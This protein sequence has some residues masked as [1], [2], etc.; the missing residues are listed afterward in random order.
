MSCFDSLA[1]AV[2]KEF[3]ISTRQVRRHLGT[4]ERHRLLARSPK[5]LHSGQTSNSGKTSNN[6]SF[7]SNERLGPRRNTAHPVKKAPAEVSIDD[8]RRSS[9]SELPGSPE[10]DPWR[11]RNGIFVPDGIWDAWD[12][13]PAARLIYG[14]LSRYAGQDG[15]CFPSVR[16][17]AS[18]FGIS[19]RQ[20]QSHLSALERHGLI[21]REPR[22]GLSGQTSNEFLFLW[23]E[24]LR[25]HRHADRV[26]GV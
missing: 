14:R 18:A 12:I 21:R 3:G 4:L 13:P 9:M 7:P 10:C 26:Q 1:R 11:G 25:T 19:A 8:V 20:T 5:V 17:V 24:R 15:H 16:A 23:S 22:A 6:I 2:A